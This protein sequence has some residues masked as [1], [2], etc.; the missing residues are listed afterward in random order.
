MNAR[1]GEYTSSVERLRAEYLAMRASG[2]GF[3]D[4]YAA[5]W[6]R[7]LAAHDEAIR[8]EEREAI[9]V[10]LE[11]GADRLLDAASPK[12]P[13]QGLAHYC[14]GM[15]LAATIARSTDTTEAN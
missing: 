3:T 1:E 4:L 14:E 9:A 10:A 11:R 7:I 5:E 8:A 2:F 6:D 15:R 12:P 13:P